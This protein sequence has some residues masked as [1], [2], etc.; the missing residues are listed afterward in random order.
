MLFRANLSDVFFQC[1]HRSL[2]VLESVCVNK[3]CY[4]EICGTLKSRC[5]KTVAAHKRKAISDNVDELKSKKRKIETDKESLLNAADNCDEEAEHR[6]KITLIAKSD[7]VSSDVNKTN[8]L[9]P[10]FRPRPPSKQ[11]HFADLIFKLILLSC[12]K[13]SNVVS[14]STAASSASCKRSRPPSNLVSGQELTMC[15]IVWISP[16]SRSSLSVKPHFLWHTLQWPWPVRKQ[17]SSDH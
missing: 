17:F 4:V 3:T 10:L 12:A 7:G 15:D 16:Q 2:E 8:F 13:I 14:Q 9:R 1:G 11:R 5:V 6:H